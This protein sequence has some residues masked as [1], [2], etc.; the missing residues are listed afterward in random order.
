MKRNRTF[1]HSCPQQ[2]HAHAHFAHIRHPRQTQAGENFGNPLQGVVIRTQKHRITDLQRRVQTTRPDDNNDIRRLCTSR[3]PRTPKSPRGR[4]M[5]KP[6][7]CAWSE[8]RFLVW[9]STLCDTNGVGRVD[10]WRLV[11]SVQFSNSSTFVRSVVRIRKTQHRKTTRALRSNITRA[12][13][14]NPHEFR[15]TCVPT[16]GATCLETCN[17]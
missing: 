14:I 2:K 6:A 17:N 8:L 10:G 13:A 12:A 7:R 9:I 11:L 15:S 3:M 1:I 16:A 4:C 5:H